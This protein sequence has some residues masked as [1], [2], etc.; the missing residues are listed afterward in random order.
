MN[1]DDIEEYNNHMRLCVESFRNRDYIGASGHTG[2]AASISILA[3]DKPRK[4]WAQACRSVIHRR[5]EL[6]IHTRMQEGEKV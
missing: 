3:N 6:G 1:E 2:V 5:E 4:H